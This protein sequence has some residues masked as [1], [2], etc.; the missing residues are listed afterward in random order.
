MVKS[1]C[2]LACSLM[3]AQAG[4]RNADWQLAPQLARGLE[5]VYAGTYLEEDLG[6][7]VHHQK[8]YR[9]ETTL[10][11]L[12]AGPK[13]WDVAVMTALSRQDGQAPGAAPVSIRL[14][15]GRVDRQGRVRAA[16]NRPLA[17]PVHGP[18]TLEFGFLV[19]APVTRVG[20]GALW[21]VAEQGRPAC[22]WQL[23]GT[24]PCEGITCVKLV[25][26]Q[27]S[28]D[29]DHPRADRTA[30]RR[31]D[32]VWLAPP[33]NVAVKVE[34]TIERRAPAHQKPTQQTTVRYRLES[35]L[36]YPGAMFENR[37]REILAQTKYQAEAAPLLRQPA[38]YH[39][40]IESLLHKVSYHI[41]H[42]PSTP[43]RKAVVHL[44]QELE[45]ARRGESPVSIEP[46]EPPAAVRRVG[47]GERVPDFVAQSL[48]DK[49]PVQ[50]QK[51][52][53][54]PTLV[55]FYN[56]ATGVGREVA[57]YAKGLCEKQ[58]G[59][60][61]VLALAITNDPEAA[62]KQH[63]ELGLPFPV[64]DGQGLRLTLGVEN[65]PRFVLV[66]ADGVLR[67][68]STGWGYHVPGEIAA[69]LVHGQK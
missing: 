8:Q 43:Y 18:A 26:A 22:T 46:D 58:A 13:F 7:N 49:R 21:D 44:K 52:L 14:D 53:G 1:L 50:F 57:L 68:E 37:K 24:E 35:K 54:R 59:K 3:L 48:T 33:L 12:D 56:P 64:L 51:Y 17:L 36:P 23:V 34:R 41:E 20:K 4:E 38:L 16:D 29:W 69:E 6:P 27:Q 60:V 42:H 55:V 39:G 67:W 9:L 28:P 31:K 11:V 19:E 32:V 66:D 40:Q 15:V 63:A 25:S 45:A 5:L 65:T 10:F 62:R 30:W 61:Q 2:I 47:V